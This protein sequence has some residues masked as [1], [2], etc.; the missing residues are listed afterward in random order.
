[1]KESASERDV[2]RTASAIAEEAGRDEDCDR[3]RK[4]TKQSSWVL[5]LPAK[6]D[7]G[8]RGR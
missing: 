5:Q 6:A 2:K 3:W 4:V 1:M 7:R 8:R